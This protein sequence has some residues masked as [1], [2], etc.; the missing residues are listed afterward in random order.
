VK[1]IFFAIGLLIAEGALA[2]ATCSGPA[3]A[4][5]SQGMNAGILTLFFVLL[6]VGATVIGF[7]C[8]IARR[9]ARFEAAGG[10][11]A[12]VGAETGL[13]GMES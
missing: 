13:A 5:Q 6:V 11:G 1:A 2:C 7:A 9:I 12:T 8:A 10:V 3:D 4:P